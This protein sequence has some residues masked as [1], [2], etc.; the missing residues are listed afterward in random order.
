MSIDPATTRFAAR[1]QSVGAAL[2]DRACRQIVLRAVRRYQDTYPFDILEHAITA[3]ECVDGE[4]GRLG[5][6][7]APAL[8]DV[9]E[10]LGEYSFS[11][12]AVAAAVARLLDA[13]PLDTDAVLACVRHLWEAYACNETA[14]EFVAREDAA[15]CELLAA[16][17]PA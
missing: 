7:Y 2:D 6:A 17:L 1:L 10:A 15:L 5:D 13:A 11:L 3:L 8:A 4:P 9:H 16:A 14:D 12:P